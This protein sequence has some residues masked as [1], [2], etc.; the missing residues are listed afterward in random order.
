[1]SS[2]AIR[3][4]GGANIVSIPKGIIKTLGLQVGSRLELS[5]QGDNIVLTPKKEDMTLESLLAASPKA[6]FHLTDEDKEWVDA[7]SVG[8][9]LM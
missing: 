7:P 3:Q 9:E 8:K 2:V 4:S 1:M 5:L 6:S